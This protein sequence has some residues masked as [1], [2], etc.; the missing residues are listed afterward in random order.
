VGR[1]RMAELS[2]VRGVGSQ[3]VCRAIVVARTTVDYGAMTR[4]VEWRDGGAELLTEYEFRVT[5]CRGKVSAL[6]ALGV[7]TDALRVSRLMDAVDDFVK[8]PSGISTSRFD[9]IEDALTITGE[10]TVVTGKVEQGIVKTV[11]RWRFTGSVHPEDART[12]GDV[13]QPARPGSGGRQH[14]CVCGGRRRR[15]VE[16]AF[17]CWRSTGSITAA[18]LIHRSGVCLTRRGLTGTSVLRELTGRSSTCRTTDH[19][20]ADQLPRALDG[21]AW[22]TPR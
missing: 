4:A 7:T 14:R 3:V 22:E 17:R 21:D 12:G 19:H 11:M 1:R 18:T 13:R 2:T 6:K 8:E 10:W 5:T 20:R 16:R 9:A 15:K